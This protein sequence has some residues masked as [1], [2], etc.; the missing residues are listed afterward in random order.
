MMGLQTGA[1]VGIAAGVIVSCANVNINIQN[2][3]SV[4]V[5][6]LYLLA[7]LYGGAIRM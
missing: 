2:G 4:Y 1:V 6:L 3:C 5:L 7:L